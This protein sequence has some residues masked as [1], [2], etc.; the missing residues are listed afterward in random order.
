[1]WLDDRNS[2]IGQGRAKSYMEGFLDKLMR[3][4]PERVVAEG[5]TI[6]GNMLAVSYTHLTLPTILLV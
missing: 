1:M 6:I 5:S 4:G 2:G 3:E